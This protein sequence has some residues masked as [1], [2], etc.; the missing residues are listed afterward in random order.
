[1]SRI[2]V[3]GA[4]IGGM[5]AAARLA[6]FGHNVT[7]FEGSEQVGGKC[8]TEWIDGYAF[9]TGPTLL[10]LPAVYRD[11]FLKTGDALE[12]VLEIEEVNP[13][14]DY[15]FIDG[16]RV[17]FAN[18]SRFQTLNAIEESFGNQASSQWNQLMLRAE[19]MWDASRERFIESEP[20]S[21]S[22]LMKNSQFFRDLQTIVPWNVALYLIAGRK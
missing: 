8:R 19:K 13:S 3:I 22:S 20:P 18:L 4:G 17:Q 5:S 10:T 15:R 14:F 11:F 16:S 12:T 9:D 7:V 1:M 21:F 6:R 2:V